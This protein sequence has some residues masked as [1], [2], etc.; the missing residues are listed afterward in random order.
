VKVLLKVSKLVPKLGTTNEHEKLA[1]VCMIEK[2]LANEGISWTD[3]GQQLNDFV[4]NVLKFEEDE[5]LAEA[6]PVKAQPVNGASGWTSAGGAATRPWAQAQP[7][8]A[9]PQPAS[10]W[11]Q[12][13]QRP[14]PRPQPR[15]IDLRAYGTSAQKTQLMEELIQR[16]L[17]TS[18]REQGDFQKI[19]MSVQVGLPLTAKLSR[20]MEEA[21]RRL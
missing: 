14:Q 17:W 8:Q 16:K 9:Q 4:V 12:T 5:E 18:S 11:Q 19:Y 7:A 6:Q 20:L 10:A 3:V 1:T 15:P 13:P 2:L 21:S